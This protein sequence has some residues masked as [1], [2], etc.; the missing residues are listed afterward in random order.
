MAELAFESVRRLSI[1]CLN[2]LAQKVEARVSLFSNSKQ[3]IVKLSSLGLE[4][5]SATSGQYQPVLPSSVRLFSEDH[6]FY[7]AIS[8]AWQPRKNLDGWSC[9]GWSHCRPFSSAQIGDPEK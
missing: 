5:A 2:L 7:I 6:Q 4:P 8:P 1:K 3:A 9:I